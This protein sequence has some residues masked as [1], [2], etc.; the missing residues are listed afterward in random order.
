MY[1]A[2]IRFGQT[3]KVY[4]YFLECGLIDTV[5]VWDEWAKRRMNV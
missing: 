5:G 3:F 4:V 2:F 1:L